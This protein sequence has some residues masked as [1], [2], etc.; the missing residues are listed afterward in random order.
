MDMKKI[1]LNAFAD[2]VESRPTEQKDFNQ[3]YNE[4]WP[5]Y[6]QRCY[7][8]S[9]NVFIMQACVQQFEQLLEP[10]M[11]FMNA[12]C[13]PTLLEKK[14]QICLSVEVAP[15]EFFDD[16]TT[17]LYMQRCLVIWKLYFNNGE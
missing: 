12:I 11:A 8:V 4:Y 13:H 6:A 16:T 2:W 17:R 14:R 5:D 1:S 9:R 7:D 10:N 15:D 3:W